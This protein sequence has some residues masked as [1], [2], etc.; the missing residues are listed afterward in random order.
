M[1]NTSPPPRP[2]AFVITTVDGDEWFSS[3][4][5]RVTSGTQR[6]RG[7]V[8]PRAG[9]HVMAETEIPSITLLRH[10]SEVPSRYDLF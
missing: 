1:P 5:G 10:M 7:W 8:C 6:T 3:I 2:R 9:L 4:S